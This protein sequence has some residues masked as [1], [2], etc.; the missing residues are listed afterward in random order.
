MN[1]G[2]SDEFLIVRFKD[3]GKGIKPEEMP[4]I[5]G[6]YVRGSEV[7][8]I[9][10]AGLGLYTARQLMTRMGGDFQVASEYGEYFE[11]ILIIAL[12]V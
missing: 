6:K 12:D 10:G 4:N 11:A 3:H 5:C 7:G 2:I 8:D 1:A 9:E